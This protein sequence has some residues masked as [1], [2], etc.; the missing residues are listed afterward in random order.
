MTKLFLGIVEFNSRQL[1]SQGPLIQR[2]L[3]EGGR[4]SLTVRRKH[5]Y[6][7]SLFIHAINSALQACGVVCK[8]YK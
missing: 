8:N 1:G 6:I 2:V 3:K 5:T 7:Q 4:L